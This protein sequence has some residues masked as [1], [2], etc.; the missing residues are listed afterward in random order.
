[1]SIS[2]WNAASLA[3]AAKFEYLNGLWK[4][5][6]PPFEKAVVVRNTNFR[7]DG[8]LDLSDVAVLD[9]ES[10]Q[11]K[12]RKLRRGDIII[13]RSGG[14]PKQPVGRVCY[15]NVNDSRAY[16]FSNF[17]TVLRVK[18]REMYLPL[19]VHYT[20][21][22]LYQTG[23][24]FP[25]QRATTGIRN[26]DFGAYQEAQIPMPPKPEQEKIAAVLWTI[27]RRIEVEENLAASTRELKRSATRKFF[28][29]GIRNEEK[30][31]TELGPLPKSWRAVQLGSF[32]RMGNGSTPLKTNPAYWINGTIPWLTSAK[33]YDITIAKA[34]QFV[35][36]QA[37][38]ECH[39]P[40]VEP[41][42]VLI[43]ITGQGKTLG[44]AAVTAIE[45]CVSQHVAFLSFDNDSANPHFVRLFLESRYA[46]LRGVALGGGSTKGALTCGYLKT[47]LI[48]RPERTEQ[49][50]IASALMSIEAKISV[51]ERNRVALTD[52]FHTLLHQLMTGQVRVDKLDIDT[53]EVRDG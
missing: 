45:T 17:T 52:L 37:I 51:H 10:R 26:L 32:G 41:G 31:D 2:T 39:L 47:F 46:E 43:A 48:P 19:F 6:K 36:P 18:D 16:S 42:S 8:M 21:L 40:R 53:S 15:F 4:G 28:T 14:G 50:E 13:E 27:Q 25:L 29:H 30:L 44:N 49:D 24:T 9:V 33:V 22:H 35:T 3:D 11:L 38:V 12:Y 20:L 23:F 34:D 7:N 5:K 1:M